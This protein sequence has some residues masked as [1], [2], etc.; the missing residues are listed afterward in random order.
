MIPTVRPKTKKKRLETTFTR[1]NGEF[2]RFPAAGNGIWVMFFI[3]T[4]SMDGGGGEV[5]D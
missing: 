1:G 3:A 4:G 2:V 5:L